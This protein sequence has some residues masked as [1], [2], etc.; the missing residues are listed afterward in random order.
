MKKFE[1]FKQPFSNLSQIKRDVSTSQSSTEILHQ[2]FFSNSKLKPALHSERSGVCKVD[3][4]KYTSCE[5]NT[6]G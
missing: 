5:Y 2:H 4:R 1:F 6:V 3:F